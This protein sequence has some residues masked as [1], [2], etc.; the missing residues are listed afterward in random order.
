MPERAHEGGIYEEVIERQYRGRNA[1]EGE[2]APAY[3]EAGEEVWQ[4]I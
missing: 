4:Q 2:K 1:R 3:R